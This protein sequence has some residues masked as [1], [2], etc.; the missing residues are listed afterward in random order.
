MSADNEHGRGQ[1]VGERFRTAYF[2]EPVVVGMTAQRVEEGHTPVSQTPDVCRLVFKK[3][4]A[5]VTLDKALH[6]LGTRRRL[7]VAL[8]SEIRQK[9]GGIKNGEGAVMV[10]VIADEPVA[11]RS[12]RRGRTQCRMTPRSGRK[13]IIAAVRISIDPHPAII[14][15]HRVDKPLNQVIRVRGIVDTT[16]ARRQRP[17]ILAVT[18][19]HPPSPHIVEGKDIPRLDIRLVNLII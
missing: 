16:G 7:M 15:G 4:S 10:H 11:H 13:G 14:A 19:A 8:R 6:H 2:P 5:A 3:E 1:R 9:E 18:L 12:L 17:H